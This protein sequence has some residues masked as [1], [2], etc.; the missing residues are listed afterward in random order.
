MSKICQCVSRHVPACR[1]VHAHHI[2]PKGLDG[3]DTPD[4]IIGLCPNQ[5][6]MTHRLIRLWGQRYNGEPPWWVQRH[7]SPIAR[8][9]AKEG[10]RRWDE[11]GRPVERDKW[12]WQGELAAVTRD[13]L[14][15]FYAMG[16]IL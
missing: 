16:H 7:F 13:N 4:N 1:S 11:A 14:E 12:K 8:E 2:W 3:P 15:F 9:L 6:A 5:H 10:W